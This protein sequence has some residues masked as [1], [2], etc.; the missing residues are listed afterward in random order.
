MNKQLSNLVSCLASS[1]R[2]CLPFLGRRSSPPSQQAYVTLASPSEVAETR[3]TNTSSAT[4]IEATSLKTQAIPDSHLFAKEEVEEKPKFHGRDEFERGL[5]MRAETLIAD[6]EEKLK[7]VG[8]EGWEK[9]VEEKEK[10]NKLK[11]YL[12]SY[13]KENKNRVNI[14]RMEY[15]VPCSAKEFILFQNDV[16]ESKLSTAK[17]MDLLESYCEFGPDNCYK[18]MYS[19]YKKVLTASPRDFVYLKHF[20]RQEDCEG[21]EVW[22]EV[23]V[24]IEDNRHPVSSDIVR[25]EIILSGDIAEDLGNGQCLV[26]AWIEVDFRL[27]LPLFM[28]KTPSSIEMKGWIVYCEDRIRHL[29]AEKKQGEAEQAQKGTN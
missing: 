8:E 18:L 7:G 26:K 29:Q 9:L 5:E 4:L 14:L 25:G 2:S 3:V 15:L 24:S 27:S 22:A 11:L 1:C 28:T 12:K 19:K 17:N 6:L 23:S 20:R 13:L 21:K 10:F 16:N